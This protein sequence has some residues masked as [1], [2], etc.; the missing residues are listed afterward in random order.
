MVSRARGRRVDA[1]RGR[2][3]SRESRLVSLSRGLG[4]LSDRF[5]EQRATAT[6]IATAAPAILVAV[7]RYRAS[8]ADFG[9]CRALKAGSHDHG[10]DCLPMCD[11]GNAS[12]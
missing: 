9:I 12:L 8:P 5:G 6:Q 1:W 3:L 4:A 11:D 10:R 2:A 7:A